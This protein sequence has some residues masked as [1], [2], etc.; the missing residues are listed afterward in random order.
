MYAWYFRDIPPGVLIEGCIVQDGLP[1]LYG[2]IAPKA[3][4][5]NGKPASSGRFGTGFVITCAA[6]LTGQ[7]CGLTLGCSLSKQLGIELRRVGSGKRMTFADGEAKAH[8]H[9]LRTQV[10][11]NLAGA[12]A[13]C[14]ASKAACACGTSLK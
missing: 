13:R 8:S 4:P 9:K 7:R 14:H 1:L 10:V 6:T 11:C 2:G 5:T 3:S 12:R